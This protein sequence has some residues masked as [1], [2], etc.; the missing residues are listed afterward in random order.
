MLPAGIASSRL[1]DRAC[2]LG[3]VARVNM[4]ISTRKTVPSRLRLA[5]DDA[6]VVAD[7]LGDQRQPEA[8]AGRLGGDERIEQMRQQ[9]VGHARPV[10]LDAEFERQRHARLGAR[11]LTAARP[12]GTRW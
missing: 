9:V 5:L 1:F 6:A 8:G 10:V 7:D 11:Q 12:A 2:R 4:G 3:A